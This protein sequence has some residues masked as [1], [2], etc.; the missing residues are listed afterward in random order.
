ML[1]IIIN[2]NGASGRT[3]KLWAKLEPVFASSGRRYEVHRSTPERGISEICHE[4][5]SDIP[6]NEAD[7]PELVLVGG[8][9]S[10]NEALNGIA[11]LSRV[12]V[13]LIPAGSGNDLA[14]DLE[15]P[16][17]PVAVAR[18]ILEGKVRRSSDVGEAELFGVCDLQPLPRGA[19]QHGDYI[20]RRFL[21][22]CGMGFDAA[23]CAYVAHSPMKKILNMLHLGKLSYIMGAIKLIFSYQNAGLDVLYD[24]R[25]PVHYDRLLLAAIM[26]HRFEGGG[27]QFCPQADAQDGIL[28]TCLADPRSNMAF[29]HIFPT[30][31]K[32]NH[33]RYD[34]VHA[35]RGRRIEL[36][37]PCPLWVHTDGEVSGRAT[38][39]V[40]YTLNTRLRLLM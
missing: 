6:E 3:R 7:E 22:S 12:K 35:D 11:D 37:S 10:L 31:Y 2:P 34:V 30:A 21:T 1:H 36:S 29:F 13:G 39:L 16:K 19:V 32:G 33:L 4:L 24:D 26:N 40:L 8:D 14:R 27:F 15:L 9:G 18:R 5:T 38:R 28:D 17:D 23:I 20:R 25:E